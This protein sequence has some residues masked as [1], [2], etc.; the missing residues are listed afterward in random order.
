MAR[1][2]TSRNPE[3]M[4]ILAVVGV[5]ALLVGGAYVY[6]RRKAM[7]TIS[8]AGGGGN[9]GLKPYVPTEPTIPKAY[10]QFHATTERGFL[11]PVVAQ[12]ISVHALPQGDV[13]VNNAG[14]TIDV[15]VSVPANFDPITELVTTANSSLVGGTP[16][17]SR[18]IVVRVT[19]RSDQPSFSF[20][21]SSS[22]N[23]N[24]QLQS[25]NDRVKVYVP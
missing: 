18:D 17:T 25:F 19:N 21:V 20:H 8:P 22:A 11:E 23:I 4:T 7:R 5:S 15:V 9:G 1:R 16:G 6:R 2:R 14:S 10:V 24:G 12:N 3:P 13:Q